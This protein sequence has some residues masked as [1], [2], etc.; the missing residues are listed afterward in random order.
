MSI[1]DATLLRELAAIRDAQRDDH[2]AVMARIDDL[3]VQ[4]SRID[5]NGCGQAWQ[6]RV[7]AEIL[8]KHGQAISDLQQSRSEGKG[9]GTVLNVLVSSVVAVIVG[10]VIGFFRKLFP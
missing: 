1:D 5:A 7:H 3:S 2:K 10:V 6:H 8:E 9:K 4:M